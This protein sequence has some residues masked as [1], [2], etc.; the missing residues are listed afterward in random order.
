MS[1]QFRIGGAVVDVFAP[2]LLDLCRSLYA[3]SWVWGAIVVCS[4]A[5]PLMVWLILVGLRFRLSRRSIEDD[6]DDDRLQRAECAERSARPW[7]TLHIWASAVFFLF[8]V[9]RSRNKTVAKVCVSFPFPALG[10]FAILGVG[11]L[12]C[13][14]LYSFDDLLPPHTMVVIPVT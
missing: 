11:G 12:L 13:A 7:V 10:F 8:Y 6:E 5:V 3:F 14:I 4:L 2:S 9:F 1:L